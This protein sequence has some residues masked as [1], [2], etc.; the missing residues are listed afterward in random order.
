MIRQMFRRLASV[1]GGSR[2]SAP[3]GSQGVAG[4]GRPVAAILP[5]VRKRLAV[6]KVIQHDHA[7]E[8][9]RRLRQIQQGQHHY[10]VRPHRIPGVSPS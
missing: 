3:A 6:P 5:T 1:L 10:A 9:L 4:T 2:N 7:R 8:N